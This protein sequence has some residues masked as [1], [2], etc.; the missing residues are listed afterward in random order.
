LSNRN[1]LSDMIWLKLDWY[2][3]E[4]TVVDKD[5]EDNDDIICIYED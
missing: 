2:V 4:F 1:A 5:C 3:E